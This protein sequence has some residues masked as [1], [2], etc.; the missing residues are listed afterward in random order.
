M[1][2]TMMMIGS[3]GSLHGWI[4]ILRVAKLPVGQESNPVIGHNDRK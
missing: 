4:R 3:S 2:L 1:T